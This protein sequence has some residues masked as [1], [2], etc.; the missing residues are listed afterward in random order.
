MLISSQELTD[1]PVMS[2][3]TGAEIAVTSHPI[4]Q[5]SSLNILAYS[6]DGPML[7]AGS[8]FLRIEEIRELSD[9]G[10]IVD[11]SDDFIEL[12]DIVTNREDYTQPL[13]LIGLKVVDT[14]GNK[15]GVVE[16]AII[17]TDTFRVEQLQVR[18]PLMKSLANSNLLIGRSQIVSVSSQKITVTTPTV[19]IVARTSASELSRTLRNAVR[20]AQVEPSKSTRQ[21]D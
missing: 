15:L 17:S 11:S 4:Y 18:Q 1:I 2:L 20:P 13:S 16:T 8:S 3:Q 7:L 12:E 14:D 21:N 5:K 9:F 10:F 6:L 19:P